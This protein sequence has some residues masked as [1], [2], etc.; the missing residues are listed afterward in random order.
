MGDHKEEID[1]SMPHNN[2]EQKSPESLLDVVEKGLHEEL[3]I[4]SPFLEIMEAYS[5]N[6][7]T[8]HSKFFEE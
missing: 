8:E 1:K 6:I 5:Q 2:V 3:K 4:K 7:N